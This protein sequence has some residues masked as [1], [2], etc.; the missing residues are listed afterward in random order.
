M[1]TGIV[2]GTATVWAI[3][4]FHDVVRLEVV[5]PAEALCDIQHGASV[6]IDGC[7]LTVTKR[8]ENRL[9]F[10]CVPETVNRT[11]L[12]QVTKGDLV[13]FE[14]SMRFGD[15]VGGHVLSG[16]IDIVGEISRI[17]VTGESRI[18]SIQVPAVWMKYIFAKGYVAING[19]SLTISSVDSE[20]G[21][22]QISLIPE[23]L[24]K[25]TFGAWVVGRH[26]NIEIDRNTQAI[27]D[28]VERVMRERTGS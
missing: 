11:I 5:F 2:Q 19:A 16:H 27:V 7:C 23:T 15:E 22:F 8:V 21:E 4:R 26:V 10:D 28:T 20:R 25:T 1:F 13:N 6:A 14:R 3:E 18:V 24:A 17:D 9:S 12:G